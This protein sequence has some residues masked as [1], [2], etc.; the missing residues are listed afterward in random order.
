LNIF[1]TG[2]SI[3]SIGYPPTMAGNIDGPL[4]S[5][6]V[7]SLF[8]FDEKGQLVP[9]LAT[10]YKIDAAAKTITLTLRKGVKFQDG[11]DFN[12]TSCKWN[13]DQY[14]NGSR[15]E[16]KTLASVEVVDDYTVR[17]TLSKFN[18]TVISYL[19]ADPGRMIS[20][21]AFQNAGT[22]DKERIAYSEKHPVG[23]GAFQFESY[24]S[25]V[26]LK[27]KRFDGYWDGKPYLDGIFYMI[28]GDKT[29][30]YMDFMAG[31]LQVFYPDMLNVKDIQS[32]NKYTMVA[33]PEGTSIALAGYTG[34]AQSPFNDIKVRQALS[35][36]I[37]AAAIGNSIGQ[38][39][40]LPINQNAVPGTT[41]YNPK[42]AGYPFNPQKA[43]QLLAEAGYPNGLKTT[44]NFY[45]TS[46]ETLTTFTG[47]QSYLNSAGFDITLNPAMRPAYV[48]MASNAK[49]WVGIL[50]QIGSPNADPLIKYANMAAGTEFAGMYLP[51]EFVDAFNLAIAAPDDAARTQAIWNMASIAIDKYCIQSPLYVQLAPTVKVK[52]LRDDLLGTCPYRYMSPKAWLAK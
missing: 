18:N 25:E 9:L 16:L 1:L 20:P 46:Q 39:Y 26:G 17:L 41:Y 8:R 36:A 33:A 50:Q 52:N 3:T 11:T 4:S 7:E 45:N 15:G 10:G 43:K 30:A 32:A 37:D 34:N 14:R 13:L 2:T 19:G 47:I 23:T 38:G 29:V 28:Y 12:A 27:Y 49:G 42:I 24:Q 44:L 22:T 5:N 31:K 51:Q 35:Y 40:W 21:T 48:D 6:C